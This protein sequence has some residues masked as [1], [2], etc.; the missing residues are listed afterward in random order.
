MTSE[1]WKGF[2]ISVGKIA[3][4]IL[5]GIVTLGG[6]FLLRRKPSPSPSAEAAALEAA[7]KA[8]E[9]RIR[10]QIH[11]E[12]DQ[13]LADHFNKVAGGSGKEGTPR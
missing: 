11:A 12:S 3:L 8:E 9:E 2:W 4:G 1:Q 10:Q 5:L 7:R 13:Q 6:Y